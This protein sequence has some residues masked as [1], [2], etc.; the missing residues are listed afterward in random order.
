M[1]CWKD[2][3]GVSVAIFLEKSL[4]QPSYHLSPK[5]ALEVFLIVL[6]VDPGS[7]WSFSATVCLGLT[8]RFGAR[9]EREWKKWPPLPPP[10]AHNHINGHTLN[11]IVQKLQPTR[12]LLS[13]ALSTYPLPRNFLN[14]DDDDHS[15]MEYVW[16][17]FTTYLINS[18]YSCHLH[19]LSQ[20]YLL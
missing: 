4:D 3:S 18:D 11:T 19:L 2:G 1:V 16:T 10:V 9:D 12:D 13:A 20:R 8:G 17:K 5:I 14:V 15:S 6:G 7:V